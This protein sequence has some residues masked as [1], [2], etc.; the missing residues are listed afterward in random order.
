[1]QL[2]SQNQIEPGTSVFALF[3]VGIAILGLSDRLFKEF[4][5]LLLECVKLHAFALYA[6]SWLGPSHNS[7]L[8]SCVSH[9]PPIP[10]PVGRVLLENLTAD[11][12]LSPKLGFAYMFSG[13]IVYAFF[14]S[15]FSSICVSSSFIWS[16]PNNIWW[17]Y[18]LRG[19]SECNN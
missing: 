15:R 19:S 2:E 7:G 14:I 1:M 10:T 17:G 5:C 8:P 13:K 6:T 12:L 9:L 18:K 3:Y 16:W 11:L 4:Y